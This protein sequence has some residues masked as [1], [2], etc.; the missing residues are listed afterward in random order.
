LIFAVARLRSIFHHYSNKSSVAA[1]VLHDSGPLDIFLHLATKPCACLGLIWLV[2][3]AD[4]CVKYIFN[5]ARCMVCLVYDVVEE[6]KRKK[7]LEVRA[8]DECA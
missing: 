5:V 3:I 6:M 8:I 4:S 2:G 7:T 1:L